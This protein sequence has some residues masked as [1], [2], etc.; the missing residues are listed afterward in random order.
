MR[1]SVMFM[2]VLVS[3]SLPYG[4]VASAHTRLSAPI[5]VV[6]QDPAKEEAD[7]YAAWYNVKTDPS[8]AVGLA[9]A[10]LEKYPDGKYAKYL[11][12]W[13]RPYLFNEAIASKNTNEMIRIGKE[14]LAEDPNN[15]DYLYLMAF[16]IRTNELSASPA[17]YSHGADVADF[18]QR[19]VKLI[20]EGKIPGVVPKEHWKQGPVLAMLYHNIALVEGKNK[21]VDKALELYKKAAD[22]DPTTPTYFLAMGNLYQEKYQA[23]YQR[24]QALPQSDREAADPKPEVKAALDEVNSHADQVIQSWARFMALT[25]NVDA[26]KATRDQVNDI[27]TNL[28]KYRHP[29]DAQGLQKLIEQFKGNGAPSAGA[30]GSATNAN[31]SP[32]P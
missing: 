19:A 1:K 22:L 3:V 24:Y 15:L 10:Y 4:S 25:A 11:K 5:G 9:K 28:Y 17:N 13:V 20:E 12:G 27:L 21:N 31:A 7:A 14:A 30:A 8:K 26:W 23:A 6:A 29:D 32:K 2:A 16:N 18:S